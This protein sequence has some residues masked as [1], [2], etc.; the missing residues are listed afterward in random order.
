LYNNI[1]R[2]STDA[3]LKWVD[4]N[5]NNAAK[6]YPLY[7]KSDKATVVGLGEIKWQKLSEIK[8]G[9]LQY[10]SNTVVVL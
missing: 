2:E 4:W 8:N 9:T 3:D 1:P 5:M 7:Q 6:K 10:K